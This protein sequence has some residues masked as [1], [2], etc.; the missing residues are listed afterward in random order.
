MATRWGIASAGMISHDFVNALSTLDSSEHK[1]FYGNCS[2]K[3]FRFI[4]KT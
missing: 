1:V 2:K 4:V 3:L